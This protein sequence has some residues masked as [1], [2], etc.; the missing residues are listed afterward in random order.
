MALRHVIIVGPQGAGKGTQARRIASEF[1]LTHLS[2]GDLFRAVLA[3]DT[4]LSE[5]VRGYVDSG[6]L[7]PDELTAEVLFAA[8]DD[9]ISENDHLAGAIFDGYPRNANQDDV[10]Q[11]QLEM[12]GEELVAVVHLNVPKDVLEARIHARA[13]DEGR[14]DDTQEALKRRLEIYFQETEPLLER[15][16]SRDLVI[17]IDGDQTI[18]QVTADI[19]PELHQRLTSESAV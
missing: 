17:E 2:T 15:W 16:R 5:E 6:E 10:L 1:G 3:S 4:P 9:R 12:R 19:L 7:V 8:L 11:H 14:T 18:E 13:E